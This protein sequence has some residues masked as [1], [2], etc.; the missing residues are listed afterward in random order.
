MKG[1]RVY[2]VNGMDMNKRYSYERERY[3]R[4]RGIGEFI[5]LIVIGAWLAVVGWITK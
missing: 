2:E 3:A 1:I 4:A 5:A